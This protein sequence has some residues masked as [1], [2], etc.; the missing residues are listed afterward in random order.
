MASSNGPASV[1]APHAKSDGP[2]PYLDLRSQ[3]K[4]I[5]DEVMQ[6]VTK[7]LEDQQFILGPEVKAFETEIAETVGVKAAVGCASGSD[8]LLLALMALGVEAGDEVIVPAFTF[9]AT[10]GSVARLGAKPVFVDILPDTYNLDSSLIERLITNRTR[11]IIPVHLFGLPAD[12]DAIQ[13]IARRRHLSVVEDAAQAIGARYREKQVGSTSEFGC[14]SFFPSKNL[15][16]AGDGGLIT[17]NS[18][19]TAERLRVLR[20]HGARR[21]YSY[22]VLGINSRLDAIQAAILRVKLRHLHDWTEGRRRNA[23]RYQNL[24]ASH[25]LDRLVKLPTTLSDCFHVYNQFTIRVPERDRLQN[26]LKTRGIPSEVYYPSPL[27]LQPA[28]QYLGY[29]PGTCPV[30]EAAC[31]EVVSLPIYPE[32][33]EQQQARVVGEIA[34]FYEG[35]T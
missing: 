14:F 11:A 16:G 25:G 34:D 35:R 19:E 8:A 33:T 13:D 27:H 9:V 32:L 23:D 30:A 21:K 18:P 26:H 31:R 5:R 12:L 10:A 4:E 15:G 22:D 24:F 17:T 1:L 28:F 3:F 20:A 29:R 2:L 7:I 6:G